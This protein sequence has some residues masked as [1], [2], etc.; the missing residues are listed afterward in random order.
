MWRISLNREFGDFQTPP[1]LVTAILECLSSS[2]I[3]W[4]RVLEPT[5]G[6]GNFIEGLLKQAK[7]PGEIQAIEIQDTHFAIARKIAE[8]SLVAHVVVSKANLFELNLYRDLRWSKTGPLLV[9]G[10]PPWVTNSELGTLRSDNLPHKENIKGLRGIEARTGKSNFDIAEYIWLK[11]IQ[12]LASEQ[13]TIALLC[14]TSVARNVLQFAFDADL[15]IIDASIRMIDA[16]KWF[17]AAVEAC[18]FCVEVGSGKRRYAAAVYRDLFAAK[19]DSTMAIAGRQL[20]ADMDAYARVASSDGVC[21]VTWRQGLKHD[22]ASVMELTYD[23]LGSLRNKLGEAVIIEPDYL[24]PLLKSSDLFN[25]EKPRPRKAVI[26]TQKR[27]GKDTRML[28]RTAPQLWNYLNAHSKN[29]EQRKSS[30]YN[31]QPPFA[32]FGI[33]DYSFA[34]YKVAISG[35]HKIPRFRAIGPV[36]GRP[37]MLDDTCYFI[38]CHS[39]EQAAFLTSLLNDPLCLDLVNSMVFMGSKRPITKKLLQRIDLRSLFDKVEQ[40][41]LLSKAS[42]E[43]ERLGIILNQPKISWP[44]LDEFLVEYS[45]YA[46]DASHTQYEIGVLFPNVA[47]F[48]GSSLS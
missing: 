35:L 40:Q 29:F 19:P 6:R 38:A 11:L 27:L 7:P 22:A 45:P 48:G 5:C 31:N 12:E 4:S 20:V 28:E 16:K 44:S 30:I 33:G 26:V 25:L 39:A 47:A 18:L 10:N 8:Q 37:V 23:S 32:I 2:G 17:G 36:D 42:N 13:P 9:V 21:P 43:L 3:E 1:V 46:D 14:K 15:P 34:P 24:Y 41:S